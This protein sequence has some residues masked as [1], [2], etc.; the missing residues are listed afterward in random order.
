MT[1]HVTGLRHV[2]GA[3]AISRMI[4]LV[5]LALAIALAAWWFF[6]RSAPPSSAPPVASP[7]A[8][9]V[10]AAP[11]P[12]AT[13]PDMSIDELYA[14]AR[15][16]LAE[17]RMVAPPGDNALEYYL[18][19]LEREPENAGAADALRE[20]FPFAVGNAETEI[21]RD[22][23]D[24]ANRIIDLLAKADPNNYSLTILRSKLD[25]RRKLAE[26]DAL[27]EAATAAAAATPAA[28]TPPAP[29]ESAPAPTQQV[30]TTPPV[31]QEPPVPTPPVPQPRGETRE[32]EAIAPLAP[33]YPPSAVRAR[34][35]GWV[36]VEFVV[37]ADGSIRDARVIAAQP[38]RIF[39]GAAERAAMAA[40]FRPK[41]VNGQPVD[42]VVRRR[43]EFKLGG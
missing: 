5:G 29:V 23:Y 10:P 31:A 26:R 39:D 8:P 17:S 41:L 38:P 37:A 36:E 40:K 16:A 3:I 1:R 42:S 34:Q 32:A 12:E 7:A 20:L 24:E 30:A 9:G 18:R 21:D 19:I 22:Q 14:A 15:K 33:S 4:L 25:A 27:A 2:R 11:A 28:A 43:I 6:R 35:Q 13:A